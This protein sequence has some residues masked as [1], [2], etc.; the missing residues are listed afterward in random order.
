MNII[1]DEFILDKKGFDFGDTKE[2]VKKKL[3]DFFEYEQED[4]LWTK[5]FYF[6]CHNFRASLSFENNRLTSVDFWIVY[7]NEKEPNTYE[8]TLRRYNEL[9]TAAKD[10][11]Y[12]WNISFRE[13]K[14]YSGYFDLFVGI[15]KK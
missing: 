7:K 12:N 3:K 10:S 11:G 15:K 5:Y 4:T 9:K 8:V 14:N 1:K 6:V 13:S 2:E